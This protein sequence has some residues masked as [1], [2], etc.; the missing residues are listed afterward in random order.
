MSKVIPTTSSLIR[1]WRNRSSVR[2]LG[3]ISR[4]QFCTA[5]TSTPDYSVNTSGKSRRKQFR[6]RSRMVGHGR[7]RSP[8]A[9]AMAMCIARP[10]QRPMKPRRSCVAVGLSQGFI[11]PLEATALQ[12]V[13][14]TIQNFVLALESKNLTDELSRQK[15]E[16]LYPTISWHCLLAGYGIYPAKEGLRADGVKKQGVKFDE[17]QEFIRRCSLNHAPH[18]TSLQ[19]H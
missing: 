13:F 4:S 19:R 8:P 12:L 2:L 7:S 17:I 9:S 15:I 16:H 14:D 11:E 6:L 18:M 1:T 10:I 3:R 5:I